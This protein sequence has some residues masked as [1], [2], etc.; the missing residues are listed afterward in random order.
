MFNK[1]FLDKVRA[2]ED[3]WQGSIKGEKA[4]KVE[5]VTYSGIPIKPVYSPRDVSEISY[6]SI[7][8]PGQYPYT[9]GFNPLGYQARPWKTTHLI[10]YATGEQTRERWEF[11]RNMGVTGSQSGG[12]AEELAPAMVMVDVPTAHGFDPDAPEARGRVGACG[13]SLSNKEDLKPL[14]DGVPL[15]KVQVTFT[16]LNATLAAIALYVAYARERGYSPE[17]LNMRGS[18]L[19]YSCCM[20]DYANFP[21]QY[22]LRLMTECIH[23]FAKYMPRCEHTSL[24]GH[25]IGEVGATGVQ[26]IALMLQLAIE[27]AEEGVRV[28]LDPDDVM[29]GFYL[30]PASYLDFFEQIAKI[31]VLRKLWASI[32]KER[33][34]CKKTESLKCRIRAQSAGSMYSAQEPYNN[35]I[36]GT[37]TTLAGIL[38]GAENIYTTPF[39]EPLCITTEE[40]QRL[41]I[42]TQQIIY[43]ETNIP[44]VTDPLA[45][46]YYVEWLCHSFEGEVLKYL[47][48]MQGRGGFFK[49]WETGWIRNELEKV[50]NERQR[51][52]D[53]GDVVIVGQNKY[54]LPDEQ[55]PEIEL[56]EFNPE[57]E[58][59]RIAQVE[60]FRRKRDQGKVTSALAKVREAVE[61]FRD[62][63]PRSCG[64][65]MP[66]MIDAFEAGATLG[67]VHHGT[68]QQVLGYGYSDI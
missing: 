58:Q 28:G 50:A 18:N 32:C 66:A 15:D 61:L 19:L 14:F 65:L 7:L 49:C 40:S 22:V 51:K 11:M 41:A 5:A 37:I 54:R 20:S 23:Y 52:I 36:R 33:L 13:F 31:R 24:Q 48:E 60:E 21:P 53:S 10:G 12:E 44:H 42:R 34:G 17:Q 57:V 67:E 39:D 1:D 45:G 35:I 9:R 29:P 27:L 26:E 63:W 6:D 25:N 68:L 43:H 3:E 2:Q 4:G 16:S 64:V 30:G 46:S 38:A 59:E 56:P 62:D 8:F 47:Q 55:Q